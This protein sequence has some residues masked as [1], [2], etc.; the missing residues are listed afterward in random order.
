MDYINDGR[1][2][3]QRYKC[4]SLFGCNLLY[5]IVL[6]LMILL[7]S[8]V[9]LFRLELEN[10]EQWLVFTFIM[11]MLVIGVP[12]LIYVLVNKA[13]IRQTFR[14]NRISIKELVLVLGMAVFGYC[15]VSFINL[16]LYRIFSFIGT[17][18]VPEFP[19]INNGRQYI[20]AL[21]VMA[22]TPAVVEEFLF[23]GII[24]RGYERLGT[25]MSIIATGLLFAFL[26]LRI[27]NIPA[28]IFLGIMIGYVVIRTDS[29]FA[30]VL[31]HFTQNAIS[32]SF[33]YA[34]EIAKNYLQGVEVVQEN[35]SNIPPEMWIATVIVWGVMS[36]FSL[37]L[38]LLCAVA[39]HRT[40]Q[41]KA[42][43]QYQMAFEK[44]KPTPGEMLPVVGSG[45]LV[46]IMICIE[47]IAMSSGL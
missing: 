5:L 15:I 30:G 33:M 18:I 7:S 11:E 37:G 45:G 21:L 39:L 9:G 38:F 23:R 20:T 6:V 41:S 24:L 4:P 36:V 16:I 43:P 46:A 28:I 25:R 27:T 14:I 42:G 22:L 8:A 47:I 13:N 12:P 3:P 26:H 17:P 29:I 2:G 40:T 19:P 34:Q 32:V 10:T 44:T 1:P 35:M 31:Y